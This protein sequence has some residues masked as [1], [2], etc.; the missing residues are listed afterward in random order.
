MQVA[1]YVQVQN[2]LNK[3]VISAAVNAKLMSNNLLHL[4]NLN[5]ICTCVHIYVYVRLCV[6]VCV[7][8][9]THIY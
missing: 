7:C 8:M 5:I 9:H 4:V 3:N 6:C 1:V 2:N